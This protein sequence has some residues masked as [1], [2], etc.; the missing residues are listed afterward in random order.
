Y[1]NRYEYQGGNPLLRPAK[2][3]S[4]DFTL[5][6][7]WITFTAGYTNTKHYVA[8]VMQPYKGDIFIKTYANISHIEELYTSVSASPKLGF[9]Q[10]MYEIRF[11]KQYFN[12]DVFG[13]DV[14]LN[15]PLFSLRMLNRFAIRKDFTVSVNLSYHSSYVSSVSVYKEGGSVDVTVYKSFFKNKLSFW[16]S[17][18]D[19]LNTQ[20]RKYTMYG[21]NSTFTTN[22][23]MDTRSF[24]IGIR[25][26]F[27]TTRNKY[28]GTG[29][30]NQEKDRL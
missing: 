24:S 26:N 8:Y 4:L 2:I 14:S 18:R 15:R 27:N 16:L 11:S 5:T 25:Y 17:G 13:Q 22:Q 12:D 7:D 29:A 6:H 10:P 23:D 28:K 30:G 21:I 1:D 19:L 20:K 3:H 9:Y